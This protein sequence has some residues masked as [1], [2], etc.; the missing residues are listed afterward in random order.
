MTVRVFGFGA[1]RPTTGAHSRSP[2]PQA[3]GLAVPC[4]PPFPRFVVSGPPASRF[5]HSV[6]LYLFLLLDYLRLYTTSEL[7]HGLYV[8]SLGLCV[9][10]VL[11]LVRRV[12]RLTRFRLGGYE[13]AAQALL[14]LSCCIVLF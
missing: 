5:W 14:S 13:G 7:G 1:C 6:S 3:A 8:R 4:A 2:A 11:G 12:V 10:L 9:G